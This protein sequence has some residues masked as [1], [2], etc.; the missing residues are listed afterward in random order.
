MEQ[1]VYSWVSTGSIAKFNRAILEFKKKNQELVKQGKEP[2]AITEE[3]IKARYIEMAG[4]IIEKAPVE[5]GSEESSA[6]AKRGRPAKN[7]E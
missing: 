3:R 2:E 4:K 1:E 6:P 7:V 5:E